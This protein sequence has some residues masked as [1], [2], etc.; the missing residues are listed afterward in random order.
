[1]TD[2]SL[3]PRALARRDA[4]KMVVGATLAAIALPAPA[5]AR[6]SGNFRTVSFV[7]NRTDE[8]LRTVYWAD[9]AYIPEAVA[10]VDYIMRDWRTEQIRR[11]DRQTIDI[12]AKTHTLLDCTEPFEIVSGYRSPE[13]NAM[14]RRRS[15]GVAKNSYHI[16]GMAIDLTLGSRSVNQIARAGRSLKAGGIG[17]YSRSQFVHLDSGPVREWG[18]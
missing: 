4:C 11:I 15:R 12:V 10:A 6:Q 2:S 13:T 16:R 18:R 9:G 7:N 5:I 3:R 1:M 8:K 17:R 14:L